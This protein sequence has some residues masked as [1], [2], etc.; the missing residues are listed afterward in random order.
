MTHQEIEIFLLSKGYQKDRF[1]HFKKIKSNG[2]T[3][4]YKL[5]KIAVRYEVKSD[6]GW[7]RLRS[8]YLSKLYLT[9]ENK[10]SGMKH[11]GCQ[12]KDIS[13]I[14]PAADKALSLNLNI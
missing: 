11:E 9:A 12:T 3:Y 6:Y 1:G 4:R 14:S 7:V 10:L 2:R 5:S 8:N 13:F